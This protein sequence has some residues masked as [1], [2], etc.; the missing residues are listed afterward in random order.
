MAS[1]TLEAYNPLP[2]KDVLNNVPFA[3]PL[4]HSRRVSPYHEDSHVRLQK[5]VRR[6]V[7]KHILPF[8]E[9]WERQGAVPAEVRFPVV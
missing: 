6:Y 2:V 3:E 5:E 9:Q 7:D 8:C 4:W 1:T